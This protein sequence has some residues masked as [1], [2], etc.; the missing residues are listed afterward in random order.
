MF[1]YYYFR[2]RK[3]EFYLDLK[4]NRPWIMDIHKDKTNGDVSLWLAN[5]FILISNTKGHSP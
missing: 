2:V 3:K 5:L 1:K 4:S